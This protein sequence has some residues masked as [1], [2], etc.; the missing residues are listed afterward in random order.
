MAGRWSLKGKKALVTGGTKGIGKAV[1]NEYVQLGAQVFLT[2]RTER[3]VLDVVES[4][5]SGNVYGVASDVSTKEGC[6]KLIAE[7]NR[8][9]DGEL[10]VLVNNVGTSIRKP[11]VEYMEEEYDI[12]M[13]T[14]VKSMFRLCQMAHPMLKKAGSS[15]VLM[16]SSVAGMVALN[17][18]AIYGMTKAALNQL[19]RALCCEWCGDGIRVNSVCPWYTRTPL[20]APVI[21]DKKRLGIILA[22]TPAGKV[23][24]PEDVAALF[25]F[26]AMDCAKHISGQ[27]V[28]VDGGF[29]ANGNFTFS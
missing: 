13:D 28:S 6:E 4:Y 24:E 25:A 21:E 14:N 5:G 29:T 10:H 27:S 12:L 19:T 11:S 26:L 17:S 15:C 3:D 2:A 7:V 18:G 20:A 23:A 16:N 22:R 1:V 8:V 9:F